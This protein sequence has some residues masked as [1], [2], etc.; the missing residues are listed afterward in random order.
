VTNPKIG[1]LFSGGTFFTGSALFM[2][3]ET[4]ENHSFI[5]R[6]LRIGCCS[7]LDILRKIFFAAMG[8][9]T[10]LLAM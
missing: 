8:P 5:L 3:T 1:I 7:I 2:T 10:D 6:S 9:A 4:A